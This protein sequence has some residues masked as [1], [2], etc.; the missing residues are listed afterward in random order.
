MRLS[1]VTV[2]LLLQGLGRQLEEAR[3]A[4]A[5]HKEWEGWNTWREHDLT[6]EELPLTIGGCAGQV[7]GLLTCPEWPKKLKFS[8][9]SPS[10]W[11][12]APYFV[13]ALSMPVAYTCTH[14]DPTGGPL[15]P[16]LHCLHTVLHLPGVCSQMLT[17]LKVLPPRLR[18]SACFH[19]SILLKNRDRLREPACF[20]VSS[21]SLLSSV[22]TAPPS[23]PMFSL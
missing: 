23:F 2:S 13:K 15:L 10:F 11:M 4:D 20:H 1:Q 3:S 8:K 12:L 14:A 9:R 21:C 18:L 22:Q 19:E 16:P 7:P 6:Q 17:C 5:N